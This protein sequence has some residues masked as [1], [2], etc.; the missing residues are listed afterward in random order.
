MLYMPGIPLHSLFEKKTVSDKCKI[1]NMN[2]N[3]QHSSLINDHFDIL[4]CEISGLR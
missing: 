1:C 2:D 4:R 3:M